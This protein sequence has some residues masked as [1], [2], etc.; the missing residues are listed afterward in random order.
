MG[1]GGEVVKL[2]EDAGG[3]A[4]RPPPP[5]GSVARPPR[6]L[7]THGDPAFAPRHGADQL[8]EARAHIGDRPAPSL[9]LVDED[10]PVAA[11][12]ERLRL[13]GEVVLAALA[14]DVV[15]DLLRGGLWPVDEGQPRQMD[16]LDLPPVTNR[17]THRS[18]P[19]RSCGHGA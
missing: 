4:P 12:P 6:E 14:L 18:A 19:P 5:R 15:A 10:D 1:R 8:A 3:G 13:S 7:E 2:L 11:P 9:V 16:G 17:V